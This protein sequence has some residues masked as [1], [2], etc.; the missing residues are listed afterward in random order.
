MDSSSSSR[1]PDADIAGSPRKFLDY[2]QESVQVQ[3]EEKD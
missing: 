3:E 2:E 1:Y